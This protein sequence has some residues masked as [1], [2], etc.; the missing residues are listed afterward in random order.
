[1]S[2][3]IG[4]KAEDFVNWLHQVKGLLP[5]KMSLLEA[6]NLFERKLQDEHEIKK[7]GQ[8]H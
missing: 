1:M 4:K 8:A 5:P 2:A 3:L 7:E 6:K